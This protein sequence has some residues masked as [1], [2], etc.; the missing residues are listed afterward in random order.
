M[1]KLYLHIGPHK[2]GS[3]FIQKVFFENRERLLRLGVNYPNFG[4]SGQFGQHEAVEKV[5]ALEQGQLDEYLAPFLSGEVNFVS[6]ENFD[7]LNSGEIQKLQ[8]SLATADVRIIYYYRNHIDMLPSW[9]QEAVKHGSRISFHEFVLPHILRPYASNIVNPCVVLDLYADVF[10][11]S[12]ITIIDY[13][14]ALQRDTILAPLLELLGIELTGII[15]ASVNASL[16]LEIVEIIRALNAIAE[17]NGQLRIHNI[18]TLFLRK[19]N[20]DEIRGE[21][22]LLAAA[23]RHQMKPLRLTGGFFEHSVIAA[24]RKKYEG[25]FLNV[26]RDQ[27]PDRE[28]LVPSDTWMLTGRAVAA[29][30]RIY[31]HVLSGDVSY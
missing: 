17:F 4:F 29:C 16:K 26:L 3:T 24:F 11:K 12:N 30:E 9:W 22:D 6:S 14:A 13:N 15:N 19:R 8:K 2:T 25:C 23:I 10:G 28:L 5:R 20:S 27:L 7:R 18:R 31:Q 21:V 1:T